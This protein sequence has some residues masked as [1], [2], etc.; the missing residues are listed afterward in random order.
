MTGWRTSSSHPAGVAVRTLD[1]G[2]VE[3]TDTKHLH[4]PALRVT[5]REWAEFLAGVRAGE[6]DT[7]GAS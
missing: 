4:A 6:F 3:I 1:D 5:A 2:T 7:E